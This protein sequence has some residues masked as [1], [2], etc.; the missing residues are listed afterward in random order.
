MEMARAIVVLYWT[1]KARARAKESGR[2]KSGSPIMV[3]VMVVE[4]VGGG[5][6]ARPTHH[7]GTDGESR[8]TGSASIRWFLLPFSISVKLML[9]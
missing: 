9:P 1:E 8:S 2:I 4:T 6:Q 3:G 7:N 5:G